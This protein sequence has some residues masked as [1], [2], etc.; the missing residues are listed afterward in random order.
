M[1]QSSSHQHPVESI[2]TTEPPPLDFQFV[3]Q[4]WNPD[5]GRWSCLGWTQARRRCR[6]PMSQA[7]KDKIMEYLGQLEELAEEERD[8]DI[9]EVQLLEKLSYL[10]LCHLHE[11]DE[12]A[13]EL[14]GYWVEALEQA[15]ALHTKATEEASTALADPQQKL[16]PREIETS[17]SPDTKVAKSAGRT[18]GPNTIQ[19]PSRQKQTAA[20]TSTSS[21][22]ASKTVDKAETPS[23]QRRTFNLTRPPNTSCPFT[24]NSP[25]ASRGPSQIPSPNNPHPVG[26]PQS[27][28]SKATTTPSVHSPPSST[29]TP[30]FIFGSSSP[31]GSHFDTPSKP[32]QSSPYGSCT[33]SS[34]ARSEAEQQSLLGSQRRYFDNLGESL[35]PQ[36]RWHS[37]QKDSETGARSS[38][39]EVKSLADNIGKIQLSRDNDPNTSSPL[40]SVS[41]LRSKT[42]SPLVSP[43]THRRPRG[44]RQSHSPAHRRRFVSRPSNFSIKQEEGG[45]PILSSV[46]GNSIGGDSSQN[47]KATAEG[48]ENEDNN[49]YEFTFHDPRKPSIVSKSNT[50]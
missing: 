7:Q 27:A 13:A 38:D 31:A 8:T 15:Y 47:G 37:L 28:L 44:H 41:A 10:C 39:Q 16:L 32:P 30:S 46:G 11:D 4:I 42:A 29:N 12:T 23:T 33:P 1:S 2:E 36:R 25:F 35:E 3:L 40:A 22:P 6:R 9:M 34:A 5:A 21:P 26:T 20:T 49:Q 50:P 43:V 48:K 24:A 17:S 14:V 18:P 45:S 19:S